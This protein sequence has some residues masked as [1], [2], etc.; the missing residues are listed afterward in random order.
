MR[1]KNQLILSLLFVVLT[2]NTIFAKSS[3]DEILEQAREGAQEIEKLK[4]VLT[5]EPDQNV[6][7]KVFDLMIN[8]DDPIMH[9][10]ALEAGLA[11]ADKL[12]QSAAF[13]EAIMSLDSLHIQ[14]EVN[15]KSSK[16]V[17][18]KAKEYI[19]N[20]G[21]QYVVVIKERDRKTGVFSY[22]GQ[23]IK[24][25]VVGT[26]LTFTTNGGK[27]SFKLKDADIAVGIISVGRR[28]GSFIGT[29]KIR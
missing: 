27:G 29:F 15:P 26:T 8:N 18:E 24:G 19:E 2:T 20:S 13:K 28:S 1:I 4:K 16:K 3:A 11:S 14:L 12:L 22:E 7:L 23:Y 10:V 5:T 25:Q 17:Q 9:N 21:Q 6:R